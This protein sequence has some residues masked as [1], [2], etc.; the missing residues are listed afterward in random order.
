MF[1]VIEKTQKLVEKDVY[2]FKRLFV[3]IIFFPIVWNVCLI[4]SNAFF[5]NK[6]FFYS[7]LY[8]LLCR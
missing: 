6:T 1:R 4:I 2:H 8:V 5:H 3:S 7:T